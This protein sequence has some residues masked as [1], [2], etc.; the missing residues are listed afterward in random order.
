MP[1]V[2]F[3]VQV[4]SWSIQTG[5]VNHPLVIYSNQLCRESKSIY[6]KSAALATEDSKC[7]R[8]NSSLFETVIL[9]SLGGKVSSSDGD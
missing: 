4:S 9:G 1:M 8:F 3:M 7:L 5:T 2:R 6:Q